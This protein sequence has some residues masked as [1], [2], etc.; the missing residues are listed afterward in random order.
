[1]TLTDIELLS[2]FF[3]GTDEI[4]YSAKVARLQIPGSEGHGPS[5]AADAREVAPLPP[6][7]VRIPTAQS[8]NPTDA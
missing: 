5:L 2:L 7:L 4:D 3:L 6:T 8:E 1:M